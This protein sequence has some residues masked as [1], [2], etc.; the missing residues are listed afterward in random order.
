M[1]K[2]TVILALVI[3]IYPV[4][5]YN[6]YQNENTDK[7]HS[8]F[9]GILYEN[10]NVEDGGGWTLTITYDDDSKKESKGKN[11]SPKNVF[12]KCAYA[13][14]DLCNAYNVG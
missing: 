4:I 6:S 10:K 12:D 5:N 14:Y 2:L 11:K 7:F 13:F 8:V 9:Y 3:I 1:K